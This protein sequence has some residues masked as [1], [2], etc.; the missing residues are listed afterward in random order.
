[1][2]QQ[3]LITLTTDFGHNDHFVGT[4]KG[5]ILN[6]NH[7]AHI[8]DICNSLQSYDVLDG[9]L[10]IAQAYSYFPSNSVHMVIVDPGVGTNRR[11]LLVRTE[12][13]LFLAPDNGVLSMVYER[14]ER[15]SVRHITA[16]HYFLQPVSN[17]FHA[18]DIFAPV[19][20][21][22]SKGV[23]ISKFGDEVSDYVRFAAPKPRRLN[24]RILKGVVLKVDKFG[25][26][27]TNITASDVPE[28][29][30][31]EAPEFKIL[32]GKSE[33]SRMRTAYAQG[34]PGDLFGILGSMGYLEI[35]ANRAAA[36]QVAQATKGSDVAVVF[37]EAQWEMPA[38][39]PAV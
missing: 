27:I 34:A 24:D 17:T 10:T 8:I 16:E 13:H 25:N 37:T 33:T 39:A 2:A 32:V 4:M 36:A 7:A 15:I 1:M 6:I 11:P 20:A 29:F 18:R 9:A 14:E 21:W 23:D 5:V 38:Q 19:A 35:A 28:V 12:R 22:L 30:Q 26:L 31:A 3:R